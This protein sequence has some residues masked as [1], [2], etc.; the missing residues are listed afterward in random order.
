MTSTVQWALVLAF[1]AAPAW[2][3]DDTYR[4]IMP[5]GSVRY[6]DSPAP[7]ARSVKRIPPPP[8]S[9]GTVLATP[10]EKDRAR[11]APVEPGR[12]AVIP[13]PERTPPAP[14]EQGKLQAPEGLP[15]RSY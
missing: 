7:G 5:D 8:A 3:A 15:K 6:G 10:D 11:N 4:S 12:T 9:T 2:A 13:M 14:A 1:A